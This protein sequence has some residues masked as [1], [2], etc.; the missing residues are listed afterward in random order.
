MKNMKK[1]ILKLRYYKTLRVP[2]SPKHNGGRS[3]YVGELT[4]QVDSCMISILS[5][6]HS[7]KIT[8]NAKNSTLNNWLEARMRDFGELTILL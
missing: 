4:I 5:Q 6:I 1:K 8:Q 7:L 2:S 3:L